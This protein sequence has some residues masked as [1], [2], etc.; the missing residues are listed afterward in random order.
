VS[1]ARRVLVRALAATAGLAVAVAAARA[2]SAPPQVPAFRANVDVVELNV[3]VTDGRRVVA[4]LRA[5]D[6]VVTDNGVK[7]PVISAVRESVPIDVTLLIDI[8]DSVTPQLEKAIASAV[9]RVR[10]R[11]RPDDRVSLVSF[12]HRIQEQVA[13]TLPGLVKGL[14]MPRPSGQTSLNDAIAVVLAQPHAVDRRQ[15]LIVF[16]DGYDSSSF[17]TEADLMP[18][19]GRSNTAV[20]AISRGA[21][22]FASSGTGPLPLARSAAFFERVAAATGGFAQIVPAWNVTRTATP[23]GGSVRMTTKTNLLDDYFLKALDDFRTS[24]L[25]RY[26]LTGVAR[27]GWHTVSVTIPRPGRNYVVRTRTGYA[28]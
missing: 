4:D 18:I 6:F 16:T 15:M 12:N 23:T 24:Y 13:L 9:N 8:S 7:Q 14:E 19:A 22:G 27:D 17:L 26:N 20:F 10:G 21:A 25:V 1:R 5:A 3:A 11:L 28:F 2:Q